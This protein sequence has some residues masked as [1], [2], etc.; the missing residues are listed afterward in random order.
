MGNLIN[1]KR[2]KAFGILDELGG[3]ADEAS[4]SALFR[5]RHAEDWSRIVAKF[6]EEERQTPACKR[7]SMKPPEQYL[8][9]MYRHFVKRRRDERH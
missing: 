1:R 2:S 4:F 3:R 7:H 5:E 8:G 9:E 6:D